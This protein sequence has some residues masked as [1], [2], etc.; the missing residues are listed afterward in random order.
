MAPKMTE[1]LA[2]VQKDGLLMPQETINF[3]GMCGGM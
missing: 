3:Y 1:D 2:L